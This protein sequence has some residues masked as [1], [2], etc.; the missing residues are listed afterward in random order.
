MNE[1]TSSKC[2]ERTNKKLIV[3]K[4]HVHQNDT[5]SRVSFQFFDIKRFSIKD[6]PAVNIAAKV[7]DNAR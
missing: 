7:N 4:L 5:F 3:F 2:S 1:I 6:N